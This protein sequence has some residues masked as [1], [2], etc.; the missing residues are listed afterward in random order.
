[1]STHNLHNAEDEKQAEAGF[2]ET[3]GDLLQ[4]AQMK[5]QLISGYE[6]LGILET[7]KRFKRPT[8][9]CFAATFA[10]ATDGY[11]VSGVVEQPLTLDWHERQYHCQR[12]FRQ[13]IRNYP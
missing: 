2:S 3:K 1:M 8:C 5:G 7:I 13:A 4:D 9:I 6:T 10:A 11:Q 12:R